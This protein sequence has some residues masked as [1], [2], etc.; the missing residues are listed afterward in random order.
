MLAAGCIQVLKRPH[1]DQTL[2]E[3]GGASQLDGIIM[4]RMNPIGRRLLL[5]ATA[6]GSAGVVI[7]VLDFGAAAAWYGPEYARRLFLW[8]HPHPDD[9]NRFPARLL[10]AS[11]HPIALPI[12]PGGAKAVRAAFATASGSDD[13]DAF[14]ERTRTT[15][16]IVLCNGRIRF[17]GYYNGTSPDALQGSFSMAKS[18][19]SLL[20]GL[21]IE[22]GQLPA[23]RTPV[24][25]VLPDAQHL[26]GSGVEIRNL[27]NM[28]SGFAFRDHP[29]PG[30]LGS[31]WSDWKLMYFAPDLRRVALTARPIARPGTLFQYDDRNPMLLGLML[32]RRTGMHVSQYFE[33]QLW[34][35]MGAAYS[36][37]WNLDSR[38]SGF[39]KMESGINATPIDYA[40]LGLLVLRGGLNE[41]GERVVPAS[42]IDAATTPSP[43][44]QGWSY[45]RGLAYG[46]FFWLFPRANGPADAFAHGIFGQ[47]LH[48][49]RALGTVI[50]RTGTDESGVDWPTLI[51]RWSEALGPTQG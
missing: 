38:S 5:G 19:T 12:D 17:Q 34:Q 45:P 27:L 13:I 44:V 8:R 22:G 4:Q 30:P 50:L 20:V 51:N 35:P 18:V 43:I 24:E 21:A 1:N 6:L 29:I 41:R 46:F 11:R 42:W 7:A 9:G 37:S 31:P 14:A 48:V 10:A 39:E 2:A 16:L 26:A 3:L 49:S 28:T 40:R 47:V 15:S 33:Q 32:E 25:H 36:A 23:V